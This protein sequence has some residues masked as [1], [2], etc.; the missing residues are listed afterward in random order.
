MTLSIILPSL[1]GGGA[2]RV[3]VYLANHWVET[4]LRIHFVLMQAEGDLVQLA[5]PRIQLHSLGVN[6]IRAS[7][8]PLIRYFKEYKPSLTLVGLWPLT[9]AAIIAWR[10]AGRPGLLFAQ[11]HTNLRIACLNELRL[12]PLYLRGLLRA[13]YPLACGLLAVSEGVKQDLC[14]L[15]GLPDESVQVIYNPVV[16]SID[17]PSPADL[18]LRKQLW[19]PNFTYHILAVGTF[20]VPKNFPLLLDAF[21]QLPHSLNAKL[22]ILGEG[23]LRPDLE[24]LIKHLNLVGRVSLPGFALDPAPWYRTADLFVLSSSWEGFANVV[25]EALEFGVPVV[26]THCQSGPAEILENGRYGT[27]VPVDDPVALAGAIQNSLL[28]HHN[29]AAL[30]RRAQDFSVPKIADQYLTYFRSKGAEI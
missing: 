13:T 8:L 10:L 25:A 15:G 21:A 19:G 23:I 7:I 2:E 16:R 4:G 5:D 11:D 28:S 18:S 9:S 24:K 3:A 12:S 6:R 14:E 26:S 20:K 22:T 27:L 30:M 17:D 29:R 1:R